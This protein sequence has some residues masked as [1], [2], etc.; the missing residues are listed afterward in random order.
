MIEFC[1]KFVIFIFIITL[2][3]IATCA[4]L[5][6]FKLFFEAAERKEWHKART[7]AQYIC[8][9]A[10]LFGVIWWLL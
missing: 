1:L 8:A 4:A 9:E 10:V 7:W 6:P 5:A 2:T 3:L